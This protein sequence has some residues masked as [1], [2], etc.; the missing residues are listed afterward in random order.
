MPKRDDPST[1]TKNEAG[2]DDPASPLSKQQ[3]KRLFHGNTAMDV[4]ESAATNRAKQQAKERDERRKRIEQQKKTGVKDKQKG[5]RTKKSSASVSDERADGDDESTVAP[6]QKRGRPR[7]RSNNPPVSSKGGGR[8][9]SKKRSDFDKAFPPPPRPGRRR[10]VPPPAK[11]GGSR[12]KSIDS[13]TSRKSK[14][15]DSDDSQSGD[16]R[17]RDSTGSSAKSAKFQDGI[18]DNEGKTASSRKNARAKKAAEKS[19]SG[20]S[21]ADKAKAPKKS[22]WE[23]EK[24]LYYSFKVGKC[25]STT[26]EVYSRLGNT[27]GVF[28]KEDPTCAVRNI[29]DSSKEPLRSPAEFNFSTHG[30]FQQYFTVDDEVDWQFDDGIKQDKP[31]TFVG[32]FILMSDLDPEELVRRCRV[33]LRKACKGNGSVGIKEIQELRTIKGLILMGVH[34]NTFAPAVASDLRNHLIKA[35]ESLLFRKKL[36]EEEGIGH[37]DAIFEELEKKDWGQLDF[38]VIRSVT[39]YPRGGG[40]EESKP[41][42]DTKWKLAHHFEYPDVAADRVNLAYSEFIKTGM[43]AKLFGPYASLEVISQNRTQGHRDAYIDMIP[44]HQ[45]T[46]RSVGNVTL[47]GAINLDAEVAIYTEPLQEGKTLKPKTTTMRDVIRKLYIKIGNRKFPAFLYCFRNY[48]GQYQLWFW[49]T[50]FEIREWI[51]AFRQNGPAYIW[52]RM[53]HWGWDKGS[54]KRLFLLSFDSS[55]ATAAMNSTWNAKR[56]KVIT[57]GTGS[58]AASRLRFGTSPFILRTGE[59]KEN[60]IKPPDVQRSNLDVGDIGGKEFDDMKSVGDQSDTE[61][62]WEEDYD[63]EEDFEDDD[64]SAMGDDDGFEQGGDSDDEETRNEDDRY[65]GDDDDDEDTE[66]GVDDESACSTK[67]S[68]R[69]AKSKSSRFNATVESL[70]QENQRLRDENRR[71]LAEMEA[72]FMEMIYQSHAAAATAAKSP[73]D[74]DPNSTYK[75]KKMPAKVADVEMVSEEDDG[76]LKMPAKEAEVEMDVDDIGTES[77]C[78]GQEPGAAGGSN[79]EGDISQT[80]E[81]GGASAGIK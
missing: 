69:Y 42:V 28:H 52:H 35:E 70:L 55:T 67:F 58:D 45:N 62:V 80:G 49:D 27:F 40:W 53:M 25:N 4:D 81:T 59:E 47:A 30:T 41:G 63:E 9:V 79:A 17:K 46:N 8:S 1:P 68:G 77:N 73:A 13:S 14:K 48:L 6:D 19:G 23:N 66:G 12:S 16:K 11:K 50:V 57:V 15:S 5:G 32:S 72:K 29:S 64:V 34:G 39:S 76:D 56:Q 18:P 37:F 44:D 65:G 2:R 60:R 3:A 31:R 7:S 54:C 43:D 26:G 22:S 10:S 61:T 24:I 21:Y 51:E 74:N 38:P 75:D 36:Y 71:N 78:G 33:D 20:D